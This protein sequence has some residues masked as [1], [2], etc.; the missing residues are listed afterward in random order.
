MIKKFH[1]IKNDVEDVNLDE[2]I[3]N[4][5]PP[6]ITNQFG[7]SNSCINMKQ[8]VENI[9]RQLQL[10]TNK[11]W[12]LDTF[13]R[14]LK[15]FHNQVISDGKAMKD[16]YNEAMIIFEPDNPS[17]SLFF[18]QTDTNTTPNNRLDTKTLLTLILNSI[19]PTA[20]ER[21][22]KQNDALIRRFLTLN[23]SLGMIIKIPFFD[24]LY[25]LKPET[26][27]SPKVSQVY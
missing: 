13:T 22:A 15:L 16:M 25:T 2:Q 10:D 12:R 24:F 23:K 1:S 3:F 19:S 17:G 21:A 26:I 18:D 27:E 9:H 20:C 7:S 6:R 11:Q 5:L 4:V 14:R 8:D